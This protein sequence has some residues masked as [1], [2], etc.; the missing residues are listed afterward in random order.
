LEI[1]LS[2][3][4]PQPVFFFNEF[5]GRLRSDGTIDAS[6][7]SSGATVL[8]PPTIANSAALS[9]T[10]ASDGS[11]Y[12]LGQANQAPL[13]GVSYSW[14]ASLVRLNSDGSVDAGFA[15][16]MFVL[17]L[18]TDYD[19]SAAIKVQADGKIVVVGVGSASDGSLSGSIFRLNHDGSMDTG[20]NHGKV[21]TQP[22]TV[23]AGSTILGF[24]Q[25]QITQEGRIQ[26]GASTSATNGSAALVQLNGSADLADP[27]TGGTASGGGGGS[28]PVNML[29]ALA[30]MAL[31]RLARK[32]VVQ[33]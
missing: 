23:P 11:I 3:G 16:G 25:P 15:G 17:D 20:Y 33:A 30:T 27:Q 29:I 6:F 4:P 13:T 22:I 9:V 12:V 7:G 18:G 14:D 26:F 2:V 1:L 10:Q 8:A 28:I 24:T 5:V 19:R 21:L 32:R 31:V